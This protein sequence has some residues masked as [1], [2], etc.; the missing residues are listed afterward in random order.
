MPQKFTVHSGRNARWTSY[1]PAI[2]SLIAAGEPWEN[3]TGSLRGTPDAHREAWG[4]LTLDNRGEY[5][6][7]YGSGDRITY[8]IYSYSTPI[9]W[10]VGRSTDAVPRTSGW[11]GLPGTRARP[12]DTSTP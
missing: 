4:W 5:L 1:A 3:S 6:R 2:A 10:R 9:A 7:D 8:V 12:A 11:C